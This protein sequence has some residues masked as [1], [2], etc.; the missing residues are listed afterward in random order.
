MAA[1]HT[2]KLPL[3]ICYNDA[4]WQKLENDGA[5]C[6]G[7]CAND[8]ACADGYCFGCY[9]ISMCA[10]AG[11]RRLL[12]APPA[13]KSTEVHVPG[14]NLAECEDATDELV[15]TL[16]EEALGRTLSSCVEVKLVGGCEHKLAKMHCPQTCGLCGA[17]ASQ[18]GAMN[19]R[20]L[21]KCTGT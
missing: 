1:K 10:G 11:G 5:T 7:W 21:D 6:D 12:E 18:A 9:G 16:S 14:R 8:I 15:A 13:S 2:W 4:G 19:R 17:L 20:S 3:Q